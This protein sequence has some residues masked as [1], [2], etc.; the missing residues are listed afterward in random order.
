M[1]LKEQELREL[2]ERALKEEEERQKVLEEIRKRDAELQVE[3]AKKKAEVQR[4]D[5]E[6]VRLKEEL[7]K[8]MAELL[9]KERAMAATAKLQEE[10]RIQKEEKEKALAMTLIQRSDLESELTCS[11]CLE[12]FHRAVGLECGHSFCHF[13]ISDYL[14]RKRECPNCRA[15]VLRDPINSVPLNNAVGRLVDK[16]TPA[17]KKG[18]EEFLAIRHDAEKDLEAR[19]KA[20]AQAAAPRPAM[21][22]RLHD[23]GHGRHTPPPPAPAT[24]AAA[25]AGAPPGGAVAPAPGP[26]ELMDP[27][28]V[29]LRDSI[30]M[31][32]RNGAAFLNVADKWAE[33][34]KAMFREGIRPY[35]NGPSRQLYCS[36]I[37][38]V[39]YWI[40]SATE[41]ELRQA[42]NNLYLNSTGPVTHL[43]E[44]L[45][46][47]LAFSLN[48]MP[49][50]STP[51]C[52]ATTSCIDSPCF[53]GPV[54]MKPKK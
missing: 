9:E 4:Q 20:A 17:E 40:R 6:A 51:P 38:L 13:C 8:K 18:R 1:A 7:A 23:R 10:A 5:A 39:P 32:R 19:M 21:D 36:T 16:M 43:R 52:R 11:I 46:Q 35:R 12:L 34:D 50:P 14:L 31:A 54:M 37:G 30:E 49:L 48:E 42:L 41:A 47:Y 3:E 26:P 27:A 24:A 25:A 28:Y 44:R 33:R 15:A 53:W 22:P 29:C 45:N 2:K